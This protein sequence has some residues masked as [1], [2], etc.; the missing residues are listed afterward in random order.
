MGENILQNIQAAEYSTPT[1]RFRKVS[2]L[3]CLFIIYLFYLFIYHLFIYHLFIQY[4]SL[5]LFIT[6]INTLFFNLSTSS[7]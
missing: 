6:T 4:Y 5:L 2:R 1:F 3:F 7:L